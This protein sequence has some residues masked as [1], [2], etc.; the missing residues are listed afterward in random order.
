MFCSQRFIYHCDHNLKLDIFFYSLYLMNVFLIRFWWGVTVCVC[1]WS[2]LFLYP[3]LSWLF[4]SV[5]SWVCFLSLLPLVSKCVCHSLPVFL[6][7]TLGFH[8][9][10]LWCLEDFSEGHSCQHKHIT[11]VCTTSHFIRMFYLIRKSSFFFSPLV[12]DRVLYTTDSEESSAGK[13]IRVL[14]KQNQCLVLS[15][16]CHILGSAVPSPW[17]ADLRGLWS[18]KGQECSYSPRCWVLWDPGRDQ[19]TL[20][21]VYLKYKRSHLGASRLV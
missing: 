11:F 4:I 10:A 5:S 17:V 1:L 14:K 20:R 12:L 2:C 16:T 8:L 18:D 21:I 7:P 6:S 13:L 3:L 9:M 15:G 19:G